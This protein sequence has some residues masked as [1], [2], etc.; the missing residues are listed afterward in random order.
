M[1]GGLVGRSVGR[2]LFRE[3]VD[4]RM[5]KK[6]MS[7]KLKIYFTLF[8][9]W[10]MQF[11]RLIKSKDSGYLSPFPGPWLLSL[12]AVYYPGSASHTIHGN[13]YRTR[14]VIYV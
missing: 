5:C 10:G 11:G 12:G 7:T 14:I 13:E 1:V 9:N 2:V 3:P 8:A 6:T 4:Q